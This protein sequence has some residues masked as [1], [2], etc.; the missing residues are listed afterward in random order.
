MKTGLRW[1]KSTF[2]GGGEGNTCIELAAAWQKSTF[3]DGGEGD[4]CVELAASP[5]DAALHLRESEEPGTALTTTPAA[6]A[7]LLAGIRAGLGR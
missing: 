3:S 2:S 4:T 5:A 6:L 1:Q 7:H